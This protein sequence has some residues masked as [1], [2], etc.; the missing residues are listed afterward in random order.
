VRLYTPCRPAAARYA[1]PSSS[2][3]SA[4]V[5]VPA[6]WGSSRPPGGHS[7]ASP[8]GR[9]CA[10]TD[11]LPVRLRLLP[12]PCSPRRV[13]LRSGGLGG[14]SSSSLFSLRTGASSVLA[15]LPRCRGRA[16]RG[17]FFRAPGAR[18]LEVGAGAG[19]SDVPWR[20]GRRVAADWRG[21]PL[22]APP[23]PRRG[24]A[25]KK[26][27]VSL[28]CRGLLGPPDGDGDRGRKNAPRDNGRLIRGARSR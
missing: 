14:T 4:P 27:P 18:R 10:R 1:L 20:V 25:R 2:R 9:G 11:P 17:T 15:S 23:V 13:A 26:W 16:A 19:K 28:G 22:L 5:A 12:R 3:Q 21:A 8:L 6:K 7:S 24:T